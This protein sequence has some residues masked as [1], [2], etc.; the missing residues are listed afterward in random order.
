MRRALPYIIIAA[1][2]GVYTAAMVAFRATR[3][4]VPGRLITAT[5]TIRLEVGKVGEPESG[6]SRA[7]FRL[8]NDGE[9]SVRITSIE[10]GC[11][12][13]K[14]TA[15]PSLVAPGASTT[16]EVTATPLPVGERTV[17]IR[18]LTDSKRTPEIPL[19][20][21]M[22][23]H[24][25]PPFII[26]TSGDLSFVDWVPGSEPRHLLVITA[27][28]AG[29][30]TPPRIECD[31]PYVE[32][33]LIDKS[34]K[35][36][37]DPGINQITYRFALS[38]RRAPP[39]DHFQGVARVIAAWDG[40]EAANLHLFGSVHK[41]I[42][43]APTRLVAKCKDGELVTNPHILVRFNSSA[44]RRD[45]RV[46]CDEACPVRLASQSPDSAT[47]YTLVA[48]PGRV[49]TEGKYSFRISTSAGGEELAVPVFIK[50]G[51]MP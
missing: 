11:G 5:N 8:V 31:L 28:R 9:R 39:G 36:Y 47:V 23:T 46:T 7:K 24:S 49:V 2:F 15:P 19:Q 16:V 22:F 38:L 17:T 43:A 50:E 51:D 32:I 44:E 40:V 18:L 30:S 26:D 33:S 13:A 12:C 29:S 1:V 27:E 34:V 3:E 41:A 6:S 20:L 37:P 35:P 21:Q 25:E 14:P 48:K 10:S 45:V 4:P 42:S